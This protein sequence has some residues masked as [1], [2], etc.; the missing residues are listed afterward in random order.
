[1]SDYIDI[2]VAAWS[3]ELDVIIEVWSN[4]EVGTYR[5]YK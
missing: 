2:S 1:M 5:D 3:D 4:L